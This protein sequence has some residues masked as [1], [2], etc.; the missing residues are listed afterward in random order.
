MIS[1]HPR[2]VNLSKIVGSQTVQEIPTTRPYFVF[3][4][5]KERSQHI[6]ILWDTQTNGSSGISF[7]TSL[8]R[9][10]FFNNNVSLVPSAMNLKKD[11]NCIV[12]GLRRDIR[13]NIP[14]AIKVLRT[15]VAGL[16][17]DLY[18]DQ[19]VVIRDLLTF[20]GCKLPKIVKTIKS[21][22]VRRVFVPLSDSAC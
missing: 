3:G 16:E 14:L 11:R 20:T 19:K 6:S 5:K 9:G 7:R 17:S 1:F 4:L 21:E 22:Q 13:D 10:L 8:L 15:I 12:I 2:G 18:V